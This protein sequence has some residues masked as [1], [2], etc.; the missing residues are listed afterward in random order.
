M[1]TVVVGEGIKIA[2][3]FSKLVDRR[4]C[5]SDN[6]RLRSKKAEEF[7]PK[8]ALQVVC[9]ADDGPKTD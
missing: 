4:W 8:E 1:V 9:G 2:N 7:C 5:L 3:I 6:Q